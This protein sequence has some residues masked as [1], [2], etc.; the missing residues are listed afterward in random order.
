MEKFK[1]KFILNLL[2]KHE[3]L[4]GQGGLPVL[5]SLLIGLMA[6]LFCGRALFLHL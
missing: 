6:T 5:T 3:N 4:M 1:R 2:L